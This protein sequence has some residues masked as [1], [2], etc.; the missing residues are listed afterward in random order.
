M[1]TKHKRQP[2]VWSGDWNALPPTLD[3]HHM[4]AIEGVKEDAIWDRIQR[5]TMRPK[6]IRWMR[7]YRWDKSVVQA[8]RLAS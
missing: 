8:E 5:R 2:F 7:P 6:P 4:A 1:S 3:V